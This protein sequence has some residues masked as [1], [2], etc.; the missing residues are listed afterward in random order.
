M[1]WNVLWKFKVLTFL[2]CFHGNNRYF[3]N[4]NAKFHI[5]QCCSSLLWSFMK[6]GAFWYFW[7][8]W[9]SFHGNIVVPMSAK[10]IQHLYMAGTYI[11]SKYNVSEFKHIKTVH[12]N[13]KQDF[14]TFVSFPW[15]RQPSWWC[16]T[17]LHYRMWWSTLWYS[18]I[19]IVQANSE[20]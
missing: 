7:N 8:F 15:Q 4:S 9:C 3:G 2:H 10:I 16:H 17:P 20:K 12:Q 18:S 6:F 1:F 19:N 14:F 11:V 5:F 13:K